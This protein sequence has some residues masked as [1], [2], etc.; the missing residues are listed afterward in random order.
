MKLKSEKSEEN[1][2]KII[3]VLGPTATGKSDLAVSVAKNIKKIGNK[4]LNKK[5]GIGA[6]IIS[7]DSRQVYIGMDLG[8]GKI[9]KKEM[10]GVHHHMLDIC[11]PKK[12][13]TVDHYQKMAEEKIKK[14]LEN[15]RIPIICGGTGFYIDA[16]VSGMKFPNVPINKKLRVDLHKKSTEEL[17][18][19]L[20]KLDKNRADSIDKNNPVRL[21]RAIEIA[22]ALGK[23]P[24]MDSE[25]MNYIAENSKYDVLYIGLDWPDEI[26]KEKIHTRITKR[27]KA[28][29][30]NEA[31]KLKADGLSYKK[32]RMFG[33]EYRWLADLLENKVNREEF[34]SGLNT[35]T[36]HYVKKQRIWF[37]RN[38]NI[39][40]ITP[41][42]DGQKI[43]VS[44]VHKFLK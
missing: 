7:A 6:E 16:L 13:F 9:T 44:L 2:P 38:K 28:G 40:W 25:K 1:K 36:W 26:L 32:M 5:D 12:Q 14:I 27:F 4:I 29:M 43:A 35:D 34:I 15:N 30:L 18:K 24:K 33:L 8:T 20:C 21:I 41:D 22:T 11:S 3:V 19:I 39:N 42:K 17:F 37:K 23:V 10:L 31:K